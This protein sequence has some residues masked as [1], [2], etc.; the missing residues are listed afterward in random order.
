MRPNAL[1]PFGK[2][3]VRRVMLR[4]GPLVS[5]KNFFVARVADLRLRVSLLRRLDV[6]NRTIHK[7]KAPAQP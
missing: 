4:Q 5:F 3:T 6:N 1:G 7:A 2:L